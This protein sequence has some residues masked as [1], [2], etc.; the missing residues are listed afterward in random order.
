MQHALPQT[1]YVRLTQIIGDKKEGIPALI[2][3]SRSSW[4][5]GI[6]EGKYPKG[7]KLGRY[8][9]AWRVEDVRALIERL[10]GAA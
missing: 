3:I 6:A 1:G 9:T 8:T 10:G 2:P 7:V 4:W 5:N